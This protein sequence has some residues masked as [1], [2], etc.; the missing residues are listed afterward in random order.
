LRV[1][2]EIDAGQA[3]RSDFRKTS[4][5]PPA[6]DPSSNWEIL[7]KQARAGTSRSITMKE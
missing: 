1:W 7:A 5:G 3:H 4:A 6:A 2:R